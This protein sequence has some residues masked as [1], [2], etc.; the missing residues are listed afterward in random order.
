MDKTMIVRFF[1][2]GH[3]F[4]EGTVGLYDVS[5]EIPEGAFVFLTGPSGAGKSTFLGLV[6]AALRPTEGQVIVAGRNTSRLSRRALAEFR[7]EVGFVFQDYRL[8]GDLSLRDNVAL[9]RIACGVA[10]RAARAEAEAALSRVGLLDRARAP[11]RT[12]SGGEKQR[13]ALARALLAKPRLLLADEPTGNLDPHHAEEVYRILDEANAAGTTV[14]VA[15]HDEERIAASDRPAIYLD[16]G[17][18][19]GMRGFA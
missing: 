9:P 13:A 19:A 10:P 5:V 3:V 2:A 17:R 7:R 15:T 18:V 4:E 8:V 14:L 6:F 1:R 16:G 12:L 11:A